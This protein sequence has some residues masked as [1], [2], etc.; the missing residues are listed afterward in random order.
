MDSFYNESNKLN[1]PNTNIPKLV[2]PARSRANYYSSPENLIKYLRSNSLS[3]SANSSSSGKSCFR[4]SVS[5]QS[6]KTP[7]KVVEEDVL[8]MDGVLVASDTNIVGS[9]SSSYSGSFGFYKSEIC[10][11]LGEFGHCRYGSKCQ[12]THGKEDVRSTC[13]PFRSKSEAQMYKSYAST[14]SGT[15]GSRP[16]LL[17]PVTETAAI[18]AQK[19]SYTRPDYTSQRF[20]AP[21]KLEETIINSF[22]TVRPENTRLTTDFTMKPKTKKTSTSASTIRPDI[23]TATFTNGTYWSPQVDGI[24]VTLPSFPGKTPSKED[25]DACIDKVLYGPAT[26]RRLPVF[27]AFCSE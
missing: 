8:V 20:S 24:E 5:P 18:I 4:S 22:S 2:I 17:H 19:D 21:I 26:R 10:R 13:F 11:A 14:V 27:S 9:G 6:E 15:Y 7:V 25:I 1:V 23:S 3:S 12:F 16:R